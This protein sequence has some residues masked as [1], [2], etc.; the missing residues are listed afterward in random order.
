MYAEISDIIQHNIFM[1]IG[2]KD[3]QPTPRDKLREALSS[4]D[5]FQ[6]IYLVKPLCNIFYYSI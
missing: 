5:S 3:R 1:F 4:K 6:K 2:S